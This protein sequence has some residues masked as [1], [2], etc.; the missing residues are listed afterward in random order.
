M[1]VHHCFYIF[2]SMDPA[3]KKEFRKVNKKLDRHDNE[4]L[5]IHKDFK[6]LRKEVNARFDKFSRLALDVFVTKAEFEE[7]TNYVHENMFTK[8]DYM[9]LM[10]NLDEMFLEFKHTQNNNILIGK[11][12]CDLDDTVAGHSKRITVIEERILH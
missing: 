4:F 3:T 1:R 10:S 11:Q 12:L 9:K 5:K 7:F 6:A 2:H 8:Q